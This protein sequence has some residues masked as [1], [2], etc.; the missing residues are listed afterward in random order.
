MPRVPLEK[1]KSETT[2]SSYEKSIIQHA[3]SDL[4]DRLWKKQL[5]NMKKHS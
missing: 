2:W 3:M 1:E 4:I 5:S